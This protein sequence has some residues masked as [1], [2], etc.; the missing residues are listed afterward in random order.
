MHET[1]NIMNAASLTSQP[2]TKKLRRG[3]RI[4]LLPDLVPPF[5]K[6]EADSALSEFIKDKTPKNRARLVLA[7]LRAALSILVQMQGGRLNLNQYRLRGE[8]SSA[9]LGLI[10]AANYFDPNRGVQFSTFAYRC[11]RHRVADI[12]RYEWKKS[13]R[14][15]PATDQHAESADGDASADW[16]AIEIPC[17]DLPPDINA[18]CREI[19]SNRITRS[20]ILRTVK[21]ALPCGKDEQFRRHRIAFYLHCIRGITY[22]KIGKLFHIT[23]EAV[24]QFINKLIREFVGYL[25][26]TEVIQDWEKRYRDWMGVRDLAFD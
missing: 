1:A 17:R 12:R 9:A 6:A 25:Q 18:S 16:F 7:N 5:D 21:Q 22:E 24:R 14:E 2:V 26:R 15:F 8:L 10:D 20:E 4:E 13:Y 19:A 11:V 23:K 3:R